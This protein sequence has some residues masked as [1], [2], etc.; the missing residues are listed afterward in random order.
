MWKDTMVTQCGY[1]MVDYYAQMYNFHNINLLFVWQLY[2][3][4]IWFQNV[5]FQIH[6]MLYLKSIKTVFWEQKIAV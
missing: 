6:V 3:E 1:W 4:R 5:M 2:A